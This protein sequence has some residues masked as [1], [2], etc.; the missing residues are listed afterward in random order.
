MSYLRIGFHTATGGFNNGI[1]LHY[2]DPLQAAG[3]PIVLKSIG[4]FGIC[5][6]VLDRDPNE[7]INHVVAFRMVGHDV[8]NYNAEPATA[9]SD[10]WLSI[11]RDDNFPA[12]YLSSDHYKR[13]IILTIINE[14]DKSRSDWLGWFCHA[15]G[16]FAVAAG[17]RFALP[18]F[19]A[20]EPEPHHWETPGMLAFLQ[21]ACQHPRNVLI[22]LHEYSYNVNDIWA[23]RNPDG[24]IGYY[25]V[26][27]FKKVV[28]LCQ[29][30]GFGTPNFVIGEWGWEERDIPD[31][32][33]ALLDIISVNDSLYDR[34]PILGAFTW[35]LGPGFSDIGIQTN[36]I[37]QPVGALAVTYEGEPMPPT[38]TLEEYL[39]TESV[40]QQID[41]G[42]MLN[43]AAGLQQAI[44]AANMH[45]VTNEKSVEYGGQRYTIQAAETYDGSIPRRVYVWQSGKP[46]WWFYETAQTTFRYHYWPTVNDPYVTQ[47]WGNNPT[48]YGQFCERPGFCLKGHDGVDIRAATGTQVRAVADGLV[49]RV[50]TDPNSHNYGLHVY[51]THE[52]DNELTGYAHLSQILVALGQRVMAGEVIGLSGN[53]GVSFG[54]HLHFVRK[55]PGETYTDSYGQ[56]PWNLFDP[57]IY[58][59]P[60]APDQ[61]PTTPPPTGDYDLAEYMTIAQA[62]GI[63]YEVLTQYYQNGT[64]V[65]GPQQRHQTQTSGPIFYHTKDAEWEQLKYD[66]NGIYRSLDTSPGASRFYELQDVEGVKWSKWGERRMSAGQTFFRNP[67]VIFRRKEGCAVTSSARQGSLLKF[68]AYFPSRTFFTGIAL[69]NVIQLQWITPEG[70][71]VE[72]YYYAKGYGL[73]G[74]ESAGIRA[75]ISEIHQPGTRPDN[76]MEIIPCMTAATDE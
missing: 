8:P 66:A 41:H 50:H 23:P 22:D 44:S 49:T 30:R 24:S 54:P 2:F 69:N 71:L 52:A 45:I 63:L 48:Y 73:V 65:S 46:I 75:A 40:Q 18:S 42:V 34:Y 9:F 61:F 35:Y 27:R 3:L 51:I 4:D 70:T 58:L 39:W 1:G 59:R 36:Q 29:Q 74:W 68:V 47:H 57:T 13:R 25:Q 17:L 28:E 16:Q 43:A 38:Q 19:S 62:K 60:L 14:P 5:K 31:P 76:V 53:T 56:W 12:E 64:W 33:R 6:E 72:T 21:Y 67:L 26:G 20:G 37:I 7:T 10:H 55:R 11:V 32:S 15:A